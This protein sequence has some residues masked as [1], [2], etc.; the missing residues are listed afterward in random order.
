MQR[1]RLMQTSVL[2]SVSKRFIDLEGLIPKPYASPPDP[3]LRD[4]ARCARLVDDGRHFFDGYDIDR[5]ELEYGRLGIGT[6][7]DENELVGF[8]GMFSQGSD[9]G[10][11]VLRR[12]GLV[13]HQLGQRV[14]LELFDEAHVHLLRPISYTVPATNVGQRSFTMSITADSAKSNT[15]ARANQS[16]YAI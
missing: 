15:M 9:K 4:T 12:A 11:G 10:D 8:V 1:K 13:A 16:P 3:E 6:L 7:G 2:G 5:A 14:F